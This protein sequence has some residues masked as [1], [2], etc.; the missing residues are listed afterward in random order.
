MTKLGGIAAVALFAT[1]CGGAVAENSSEQDPC[2]HLEAFRARL[3]AQGCA[4]SD[5]TET[6]T[7]T[8][9][10]SCEAILADVT[11]CVQSTCGTYPAATSCPTVTFADGWD[12]ER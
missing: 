10:R 9:W 7:P 4:A 3:E 5:L 11:A 1:A 12:G 6:L 8:S 2:A